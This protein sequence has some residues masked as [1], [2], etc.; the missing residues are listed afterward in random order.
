MDYQVILVFYFSLI[1]GCNKE[2][3]IEDSFVPAKSNSINQ[4]LP[5]G[6]SRVEGAR[7]KYESFR[8]ELW[9]DLTEAGF[10]F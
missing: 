9:K 8:Y 2:E 1:N 10:T 6:A 5:L 3:E 4:I 7:P